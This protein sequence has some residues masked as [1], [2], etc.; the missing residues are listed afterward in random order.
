MVL[1]ALTHQQAA[2]FLNNHFSTNTV[3]F[4]KKD[5]TAA[6]IMHNLDMYYKYDRC[7]ILLK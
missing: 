5:N 1:T 3:D 7:G 2:E 4:D 6:S